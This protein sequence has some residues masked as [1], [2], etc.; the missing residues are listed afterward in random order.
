GKSYK[1][2]AKLVPEGV[3]GLVPCSG[4]VA[5]MVGRMTESLRSGMFYVGA[6]TIA[7]LYDLAHFRPITQA[8]LHESHPHDIFVTR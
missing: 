3:E 4:S 7:E 5:D 1:S 8:S 6:Q 2:T